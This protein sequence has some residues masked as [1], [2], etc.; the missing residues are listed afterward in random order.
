LDTSAA[1]VEPA[2]Q[3]TEIHDLESEQA[4]V[5]ETRVNDLDDEA[6]PIRENEN[7]DWS[8]KKRK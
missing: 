3:E 7:S 2:L 8:K 4:G 6:M 5:D 1:D